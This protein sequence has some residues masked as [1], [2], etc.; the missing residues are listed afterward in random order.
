M[1]MLEF[2]FITMFFPMTSPFENEPGLLP[3]LRSVNG[4]GGDTED[5]VNLCRGWTGR[6]LG[7]AGD[8]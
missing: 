8:H 4:S 6:Q 5:E 7:T 3:I 1:S 2:H